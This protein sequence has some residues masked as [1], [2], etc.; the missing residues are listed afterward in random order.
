[1]TTTVRADWKPYLACLSRLRLSCRAV[2]LSPDSIAAQD[3]IYAR[4]LAA[5]DPVIVGSAC[6]EWSRTK[7]FWPEL[8]ELLALCREHERLAEVAAR[9]RLAPPEPQ[10][11]RREPADLDHV[12]RAWMN[13]DMQAEEIRKNPSAHP[14]AQALLAAHANFRERRFRTNPELAAKY[15]GAAQ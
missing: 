5:F 14:C 7:Q 11:T 9:P 2:D 12:L 4:Q 13:N 8:S 1:M 6:D 15:Y 10:V 3:R